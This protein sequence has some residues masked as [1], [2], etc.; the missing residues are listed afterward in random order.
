M[1]RILLTAALLSAH[2]FTLYA[3]TDQRTT[4]TKI[5]DLL[6]REPAQNRDQLNANMEAMGALGKE[7]LEQLCLMLN[8]TGKGDNTKMEYA[9]NSYSYYILQQ[10]KT[11]WRTSASAAYCSALAKTKDKENKA[12]IIRQL[13]TVAS[14]DAVGCL[15]DYLKDERLADPAARAL[16][17]IHSPAADKVLADALKNSNGAI[18]YT[19]VEALGDAAY[20]G[21]A[22]AI[23]GL[24]GSTDGKL[25]KVVY[26][27]LGN[28][29]SP[30]SLKLLADAAKKT[31]YTYDVTDATTSYLYYLNNLSN[32]NAAIA[33]KA[34][35]ELL[36]ATSTDKQVA[37]RTAALKLL[38]KIR[39]A[40]SEPLL[41]AAIKSSNAQYREA[42][43]KFA[44][45]SLNDQNTA[46][47]IKQ[48]ATAGK[49]QKAEIIRML[50]NHQAASAQSAV[51]AAIK[52]SD[53]GVKLAAIQAAGKIGG[54]NAVAALLDVMKAGNKQETDAAKTSLLSLKGNDVAAQA[55]KL[56]ATMPSYSKAALAEVIAT[57]GGDQYADNII[58]LAQ[59][60]DTTVSKAAFTSLKGTASAGNISKLFPL[61]L[62]AGNAQNIA[63]A[64]DAI[65]VAE[66]SI[67]DTAQRLQQ[68]QTA[69]QQAPAAKQFLFFPLLAG[70]GSKDALPLITSAFD[71][72]DASAKE[73][74]IDALS[75][76]PS[77]DATEPLFKL[78]AQT[79]GESSFNGLLHYINNTGYAGDQKLLLLRR[80]MPLAKTSAQK[81][82]VLKSVAR[83]N[84]FTALV[85]AAGYLDDAS[86]NQDAAQAVA[87]IALNNPGFTGDIVKKALDKTLTVLS[88]QDS[89]YQKQAIRKH[90]TEMPAGAGFVPLFNGKDLTG[91]KGLVAN[92]VERAKMDAASLAKA[93]QK[94]DSAM[95]KGWVV[96]DG[97]LV[98]TGHGDNLCTD[99]K[100]GDFEMYVDWKITKE[101]DAGIY[102]RG[103][104]QVQIWDTSRV[105]VG[106]QVGSGGLY[107]NEANPSKPLKLADNA[108][109]EWNNFH[110]IMKGDRVTVYLNGELV[111]NNTVLENYWDRKQP[112][113]PM[114]QIELQA[115]G[116]YVAYRDIYLKE[117]PQQQPVALS[118][119][120]KKDGFKLLFNGITLDEWT[121]NKTDYAPEDGTISVNPKNG[122]HGNLYTKDEYS[123]FV[124]RFEFQLTPGANNGIGIRAPLEGD[125]AYV[126]MEIQVLDNEA[127]I[128]KDLHEYQYHGSVYGVIPAKRGYLKPMGEWNTEEITAIGNKI[129]VVLNGTTILDGDI[130]GSIANGTLD[131]KEHPGL[132]NKT[133]HIGFLGH[134]DML[135]FRNIR[136]K[137]LSRK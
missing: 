119:E 90:L 118:D 89:D 61:L 111:V 98:F 120:E 91:W 51:I 36:T 114:E 100:Y 125:A 78:A 10:G 72:G 1:K 60:N 30:A 87:N 50:G 99:K 39:G 22:P 101:G 65:I 106:A 137:D 94:A 18:R 33:D 58:S 104:P 109:G 3:Q 122:G 42:A 121:G 41:L 113:F 127:D 31:G 54:T 63:A 85:Y 44:G 77:A 64:Q 97:L 103:S 8:E 67:P 14:N 133:G 13:Q 45:A 25:N 46:V 86:A 24:A 53:A 110:I 71:K 9:L 117:L 23:A 15:Q 124:Y 2:L 75:A 84:S 62:S 57:R 115:H 81:Q 7:G 43:L 6:A 66:H 88:G 21:A 32:K 129:K 79:S 74:V 123:D 136:V 38:V 102:L 49:P 128:Y 4:T 17:K 35:Q 69:M 29:A 80:A 108:I 112:I 16:I 34:A 68:V 130:T 82:Q 132:K 96:K 93:Q 135:K 70:T 19:L 95:Q 105:D 134:G 27:A 28:I 12:F 47:W 52:D 107:N 92:P 83:C 5:A 55:A 26:Y 73:A 56:L 116:T 126:G 40:K 48:L 20:A 59:D 76:W 131:K 37:A 11:A